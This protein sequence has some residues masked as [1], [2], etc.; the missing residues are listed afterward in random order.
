MIPPSDPPT[1]A[2]NFSSTA[3]LT[4]TPIPTFGCI[5]YY[6]QLSEYSTRYPH[7]TPPSL[8][9]AKQPS[10]TGCIYQFSPFL[11]RL[12]SAM[13][14]LRISL[15]LGPLGLAPCSWHHTRSSTYLHGT[16]S[17]HVVELI[18]NIIGMLFAFFFGGC[19]LEIHI[20]STHWVYTLALHRGSQA[21]EAGSGSGS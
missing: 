2:T 19:L 5:S 1:P 20:G 11:P 8:Y 9:R 13:P 10:H 6:P 18:H 17:R 4:H 7:T 12:S 3:P 15:H 16:A 14:F 21:I